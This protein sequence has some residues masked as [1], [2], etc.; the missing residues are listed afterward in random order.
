ME[1]R[2]IATPV[3]GRYLLRERGQRLLVGF[4]GY[5]ENAEAH[6]AQLEKIPGAGE[7][8]VASV[9]ALHPFYTRN[10]QAVVASWMTRIDREH[11]IAD[12][13]EYVR[14]VVA[15]IGDRQPLV[16]IGFSQGAAMA[17]RASSHIRCDG[18][19]VLGGDLP[20]DVA[21]QDRVQL[22]RRILVGRGERDEWFTDEKLKKDLSF[23]RTA[24]E[25]TACVFDGA[26]EWTD[27]FRQAAGTF[28]N[29]LA[30]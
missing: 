1:T 14:R 25:V 16:F 13:I 23:L 5:A 29:T 24:A 10:D 28:L 19:I 26:H 9:Q 27:E 2:L 17:Y 21:A 22:P 7:W 12:N 15:E 4:H 6:L 11:A 20:P 30:F 3:H 8:T 18:L